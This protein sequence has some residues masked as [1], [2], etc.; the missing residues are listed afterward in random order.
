MEYNLATKFKVFG[1]LIQGKQVFGIFQN[2]LFLILRKSN[3]LEQFLLDRV[4]GCDVVSRR[5]QSDSCCSC[6]KLARGIGTR[7]FSHRQREKYSRFV[8]HRRS[9]DRRNG[10]LDWNST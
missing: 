7:T 10:L 9:F 1:T 6:S 5:N 3:L 4:K 8:E 2:R